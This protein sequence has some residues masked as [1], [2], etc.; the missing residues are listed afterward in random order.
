MKFPFAEAISVTIFAFAFSNTFD[1]LFS[2]VA[3]NSTCS[4]AIFVDVALHVFVAQVVA[5]VA[6]QA[7]APAKFL[8]EFLLAVGHAV[9][10][11]RPIPVWAHCNTGSATA[12]HFST[13][14]IFV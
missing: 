4:A 10:W 1:F 11:R 9:M 5:G 2:R 14:F 8:L 3:I 12:S 6:G 13:D 7:F